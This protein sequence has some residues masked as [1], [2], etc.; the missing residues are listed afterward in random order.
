MSRSLILASAAALALSLGGGL[1]A[2]ASADPPEPGS[3]CGNNMVITTIGTC[4]TVNVSCT[5]YD[6]MIIGRVDRDGRC[7]FPGING[8]TW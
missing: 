3:A 2:T 1:G 5:G 7:V 8:T 4:E 6:G